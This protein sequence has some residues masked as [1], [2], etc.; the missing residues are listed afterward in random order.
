MYSDIFLKQLLSVHSEPLIS[1]I[2]T[3][4]CFSSVK[5]IGDAAFHER[6]L[7]YYLW[8]LFSKT[9]AF[10]LRFWG[11]SPVSYNFL[12]CIAWSTIT[13]KYIPVSEMLLYGKMYILELKKYSNQSNTTKCWLAHRASNRNS[14]TAGDINCCDHFGKQHVVICHSSPWY[15]P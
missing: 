13:A 7:F 3:Q 9:L 2:S 12:M 14:H 8:D 11:A 15:I 4:C 1:V 10:I 5:N 6:G